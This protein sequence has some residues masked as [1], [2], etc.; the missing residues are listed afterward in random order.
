MH[1][2]F[3]LMI[4]EHAGT[5]GEK[6][7]LGSYKITRTL[8]PNTNYIVVVVTG[9]RNIIHGFPDTSTCES[10]LVDLVY[11]QKGKDCELVVPTD[12]CRKKVVLSID[13]Y[14]K[15]NQ[16]ELQNAI[17]EASK[18]LMPYGDFIREYTSYSHIHTI[19]G[20]YVIYWELA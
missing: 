16:V 1:R 18:N 19:P 9:D 17:T 2:S 11:I 5:I 3:W 10:H 7:K 6:R 20:N 13:N 15:V 4:S 12:I 14:D 8:W